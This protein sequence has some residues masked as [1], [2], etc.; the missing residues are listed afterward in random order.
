LRLRI[1][2]NRVEIPDSSHYCNRDE[3]RIAT[4]RMVE[5][6]VAFQPGD[7]KERKVG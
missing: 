1:I 4:V 5:S 2:G 3:I 7:G 6:V